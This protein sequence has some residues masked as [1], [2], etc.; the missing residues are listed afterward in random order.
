MN[1]TLSLQE[2]M[3]IIKKRLLLIIGLTILATGIA[4]TISF[5]VLTPIYQ[6]Q[7][8]ILI[9]Q[10]H[11]SEEVYSRSQIEMDLY[12]ISTYNDI[13]TSPIILNK[14][15]EKLEIDTSL[16]RLADQITLSSENGSKVIYM[17]VLD[18]DPKRAVD[19]ANTTAE[20]FQKEVPNLL[21]V[22]NINI[23]SEAKIDEANTPVSPNKKRNIAIGVVIGIMLGVGLAILLETLDTT[24]K[25]EKDVEDILGLPIMGIVSSIPLEKNPSLKLNRVRG[26]Q[27]VYI[28]K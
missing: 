3:K 17:D 25:N 7:T 8:Q 6:A 19:I 1:E 2:I 23:L 21:N 13:I 11:D 16:K 27:G 10:K 5:Y 14:V 24:I 4:I 12:L 15:V 26:N 18:S 20:V 9:D 22:D 28:E